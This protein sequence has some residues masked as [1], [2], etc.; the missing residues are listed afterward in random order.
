M[1]EGGGTVTEPLDAAML[2]R[3]RDVVAGAT[4]AFSRYQ[5]HQ[6]LER[7]E[8]FFWSF[9]DDYLELVKSRAYGTKD[10]EPGPP[11]SSARAALSLALS[12]QLRL[13]AP[14]L[15]FVTEEVWSWWQ[16]GSIHRSSWPKPDE[17]AGQEGDPAVLDA[18]AEVLG[19]VRRA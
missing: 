8:G 1:A 13:L 3:L 9:C 2:T 6:A 17:L 10:A 18:V 16:E 14:F 4:D 19:D 11:T 12:V 15:P 5:Y 7:A